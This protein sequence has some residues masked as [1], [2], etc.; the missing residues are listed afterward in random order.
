MSRRISGYERKA[1][2]FYET[3][4]WVTSTLL[5]HCAIAPVVL[6]PACGN[7]AIER[8]LLEAGHRV[9]AGDIEPGPRSSGAVEDFLS[10]DYE[11]TDAIREIG[12]IVTNPPFSRATEFAEMAIARM[13]RGAGMVALLLPCDWDHAAKRRHLFGG[14]AQ[15]ARKIVLTRRIRWMEGTPDDRGK[16]P[17]GNHA[18]YIWDWRHYGAPSL[19]YMQHVEAPRKARG[20]PREEQVV[21]VAA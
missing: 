2:D 18:W 14:C 16:Q 12:A 3:P 15:F 20:R 11:V 1:N 7:G 4:A 10:P 19:V 8:V 17:M 21:Q 9:I 6:E 5:R 13:K